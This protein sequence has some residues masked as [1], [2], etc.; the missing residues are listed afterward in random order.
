MTWGFVDEVRTIGVDL[1]DAVLLL[2]E[3]GASVMTIEG[4]MEF[5][6]VLGT[7]LARSSILSAGIGQIWPAE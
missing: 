7:S 5:W 2:H 6:A 1:C 3:K 4:L